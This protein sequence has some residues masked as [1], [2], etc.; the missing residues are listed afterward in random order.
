MHNLEMNPERILLEM[1]EKSRR[2]RWY[3]CAKLNQSG[4]AGQYSTRNC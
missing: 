1:R 3:E 2:R 4:Q